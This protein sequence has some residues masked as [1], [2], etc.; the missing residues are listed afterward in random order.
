[1]ETGRRL[2]AGSRNRNEFVVINADDFGKVSVLKISDFDERSVIAGLCSIVFPD[3]SYWNLPIATCYEYERR[4]G[5]QACPR[6]KTRYKRHKGSAR[7]EG[8]EDED[9]D[10]DIYKELNYFNFVGKETV[11]GAA[12]GTSASSELIA[13]I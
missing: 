13:L 4:E 5:S 8:D 2:V 11:S 6:C 1:M 3:Y 9:G 7:V 12:S 10:D